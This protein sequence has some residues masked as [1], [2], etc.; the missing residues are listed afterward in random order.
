MG[1]GTLFFFL[2]YGWLN[3]CWKDRGGGGIEGIF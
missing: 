3:V 2:T 1:M